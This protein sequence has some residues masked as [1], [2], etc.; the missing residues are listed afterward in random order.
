MH[1]MHILPN[2]DQAFS[3]F[4]VLSVT[5]IYALVGDAP[6]TEVGYQKVGQ[7]VGCVRDVQWSCLEH[8]RAK[9]HSTLMKWMVTVKECY[10]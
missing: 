2:T 8:C 7:I 9:F 4:L 5:P 6:F 3:M 1:G 10:G